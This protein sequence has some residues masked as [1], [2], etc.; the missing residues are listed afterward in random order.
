MGGSSLAPEVITRTADVPLVVLDT[1]DAAQVADALAGDLRRTVLVVSSKS[2]STVETDSHRRIF[3]KAFADA[4]IDAA[5]PDRGGHRPGL[6]AGEARGGGGVPQGVHGRPARGWPLLGADRVRA[7]ARG[8][9]RRGHRRVAGRRGRRGRAAAPRL[10]GQP[11]PASGGRARGAPLH[12]RGEGRVR[13][14]RLG[15][16]RL[17]RLGGAA[18]RG[19]HRQERH[20]PAAGGDRGP[21]RSGLRRR[22]RRRDHGRPGTGRG[23]RQGRHLRLARRA[24][25]A[26]G[27]RD[28]GGR[29][30][31][32]ASTRSTSPT[33]R[34]PRRRRA[35]CWTTRRRERRARPR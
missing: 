34:P 25:A 13:R 6:A 8:S 7:G 5:S 15:R 28:R 10:R 32:R 2:G 14:H 11:G 18:D 20:R 12:R 1:T 33:S 30:D 4:G 21:G 31:A 9:R 23:W 35:R 26:V 22:A 29:P 27:V 19:V 17:P 24:D 3:A 16:P